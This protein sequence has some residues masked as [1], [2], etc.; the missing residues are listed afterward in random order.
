MTALIL[1][2]GF[3]SRIDSLTDAPK[4]LLPIANET[5]LERHFRIWKEVGIKQA[6]VVVGYRS[7]MIIDVLEEYGHDIDIRF[8]MN[9]DYKTLGNIYSLYV[10]LQAVDQSLAIFDADLVYD[11]QIL[12]D[13]ITDENKDQILIGDGSLDDEECA[14]A[15]LDDGGMVRMTIDKRH[16]TSDELEQFHFGGEAVGIL[17]F[18]Y[19]SAL[20]LKEHAR[21]F[22]SI[23]NNRGL[24]WEHLMNEFLTGHSMASHKIRAGRWI[25]IDT[26]DDYHLA[27][28]MFE[29]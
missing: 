2:A 6:V 18:S 25:E 4:S 9:E 3:G 13:F 21:T 15:L 11:K 7:E 27:R 12:L 28:R 16:V 8:V 29:G 19:E 24:N 22:L 14:K 26:P 20:K 23:D 10:G 1:A 5:I 17:K